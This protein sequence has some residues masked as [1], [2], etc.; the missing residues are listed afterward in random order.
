MVIAL[1]EMPG[2]VW[3]SVAEKVAYPGIIFR[4]DRGVQQAEKR[5][6]PACSAT[7]TYEP[8]DNSDLEK[9]TPEKCTIAP[10]YWEFNFGKKYFVRRHRR[11]RQHLFTPDET[12]DGPGPRE[13]QY[14]RVTVASCL[15]DPLE[16]DWEKV[17]RAALQT[18][19]VGATY[20]FARDSA[21]GGC[22]FEPAE[23]VVRATLT[24][25][26]EVTAS[27]SEFK[28]LPDKKVHHFDVVAGKA[29]NTPPPRR[30]NTFRIPDGQFGSPKFDSP[31]PTGDEKGARTSTAT[32]TCGMEQDHQQDPRDVRCHRPVE[33]DV[34]DDA[35]DGEQVP[36]PDIVR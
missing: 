13:L 30:K 10:D 35:R 27:P 5:T 25:G 36:G 7:H 9:L 18:S 23:H 2:G 12:V 6:A 21:E 16:D 4:R 28:S 26:T 34:F 24:D 31:A 3:P 32:A 8:N 14:R 15:P 33:L 20:F 1:D 17:G 29:P 19:W 11:P 22:R